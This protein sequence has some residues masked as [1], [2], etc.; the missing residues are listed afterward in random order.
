MLV[1]PCRVR[2]DRTRSELLRNYVVYS[3]CSS[4]TLVDLSSSL[5]AVL[6]RWRTTAPLGIGEG[7]W[8][9][10]RFVTRQTFCAS[11]RTWPS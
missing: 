10:V 6:E 7:L 1:W 11:W 9:I 5:V 4:S 3:F 2:A 8:S